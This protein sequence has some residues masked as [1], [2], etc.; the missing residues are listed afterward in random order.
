LAAGL[1]I[2]PPAL[3]VVGAGAL[4]YGLRP[5]AASAFTYGLVVWSLLVE[6]AASVVKANRWL[7]DTSV[8]AHMAPAPA[9]DPNWPAATALVCLGL[10]AAGA[11]VELFARRDLAGA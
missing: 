2:A 6:F 5:R 11:G 8:L 4:A 1:N 9:A 3:F 10:V 7:L